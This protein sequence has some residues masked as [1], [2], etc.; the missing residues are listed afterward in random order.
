MPINTCKIFLDSNVILSGLISDKGP[1]RIIL[2]VLT[3]RLPFLAGSTGKYNL[4]EI[5]RNL[6]KKMPGLLSAYKRYLPRLYLKIIPLPRQAE[7]REYSGQIMDKD[8]PVLVS[9][10]RGKADFLITGDKQHFE[11]LKTSRK[12]PFK[13]V[14]P[15]DFIDDILP[16]IIKG[17]AQEIT[18]SG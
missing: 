7:L 5:E 4:I 14:T 6:K 16:E 9:A 11:R 18:R 3:L 8:I 12:Y 13:I 1:P 2:D 17:V 10:I 15:S